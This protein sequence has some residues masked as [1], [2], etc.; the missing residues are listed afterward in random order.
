MA[1]RILKVN[2]TQV[3]PLTFLLNFS[4]GFPVW[5]NDCIFL[6]V[7]PTRQSW[8]SHILGIFCVLSV[9]MSCE[10]CLQNISRI[11]AFFLS[12]IFF[13]F[14]FIA[15]VTHQPVF[16]LDFGQLSYCVSLLPPWPPTVHLHREARMILLNNVLDHITPLL[17][18][19]TGFPPCVK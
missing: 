10:L 17:P 2:M 13:F 18:T 6:H 3:E 5:I 1:N 7:V 11:Q 16:G 14:F 4:S 15:S 19:S 12:F 9:H 8:T